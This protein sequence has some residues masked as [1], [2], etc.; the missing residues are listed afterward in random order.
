MNYIINLS[1]DFLSA[2]YS[3]I[4]LLNSHNDFEY[5]LSSENS[6]IL[7]FLG[8]KRL[9]ISENLD[10]IIATNLSYM[11][12]GCSS[13]LSITGL[14]KI[15][16]KNVTNISHMFEDCSLL[17]KICDIFNWD[18]ENADEVNY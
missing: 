9:N 1:H 14:S 15:N 3:N 4:E 2:S 12:Y 6:F 17:T 8:I 16:T 10:N 18:T 13:L 7:N 5:S 11:F